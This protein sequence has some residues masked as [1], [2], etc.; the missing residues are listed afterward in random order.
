MAATNSE[1]ERQQREYARE[2]AKYEEDC[3]EFKRMVCLN[4][5]S[6]SVAFALLISGFLVPG[7]HR[8][9]CRFSAGAFFLV[10]AYGIAVH[11]QTFGW[12][13]FPQRPQCEVQQVGGD[14]V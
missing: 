13:V 12:S 6:L 2:P 7:P 11:Q 5:V 1:I 8:M 3:K 14:M 10:S 4:V 9:S